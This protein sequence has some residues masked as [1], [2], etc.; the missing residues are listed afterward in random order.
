MRKIIMS[1]FSI[2]NF[3]NLWLAMI[4]GFGYLS[5]IAWKLRTTI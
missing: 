3:T 4:A 1:S 2:D 5:V